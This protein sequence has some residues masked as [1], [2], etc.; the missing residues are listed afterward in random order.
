M[1]FWE[2]TR[3]FWEQE[4]IAGMPELVYRSWLESTVFTTNTAKLSIKNPR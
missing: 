2:Y 4:K 3:S 1:L